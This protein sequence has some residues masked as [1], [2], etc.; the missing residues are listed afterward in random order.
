MQKINTIDYDTVYGLRYMDIYQGDIL[1]LDTPADLLVVSSYSGNYEP[2]EDTLMG[3]LAEKGI[4]VEQA[5][6][7]PALDLRTS[8]RGAF[9][10][11]TGHPHIRRLLVLEMKSTS[12]VENKGLDLEAIFTDLE[13][14]LSVAA[15]KGMQLKHIIIPLLGTG[16]Q[17]I[18]VKKVASLLP[19]FAA[20]VLNE[21]SSLERISFMD[22]N[23]EKIK[24]LSGELNN[25]LGRSEL[26]LSG[27]EYAEHLRKSIRKS[28]NYLKERAG[29][30]TRTWQE[31][32]DALTRPGARGHDISMNGRILLEY[33][34]GKV[35]PGV[36]HHLSGKIERLQEANVPAK[37]RSAMH[38]ARVFGNHDAH[39]KHDD[40]T[41]RVSSKEDLLLNLAAIERFLQDAV[42]WFSQPGTGGEKQLKMK[43]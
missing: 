23:A 11:P 42:A 18:P 41:G 2:L 7:Q 39:F 30:D 12:Y 14:C 24:I 9:S 16:T 31:A 28:L 22:R 38:L 5:M 26:A 29:L 43:Q 40:N 27:H 20:N 33:F 19:P 25:L 4:S 10:H 32:G 13:I 8:L 34:T 35:L 15:R 37:T 3:G 17:Q 21:L 1:E 6:E 36:N